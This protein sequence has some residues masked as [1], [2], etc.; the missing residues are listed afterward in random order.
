MREIWIDGENMVNDIFKLWT[1]EYRQIV[2][3]GRFGTKVYDVDSIKRN[4]R[5]IALLLM[6]K[7]NGDVMGIPRNSKNSQL[8]LEQLVTG[9][10][11]LFNGVY[12]GA[13]MRGLL[14]KEYVPPSLV[15]HEYDELVYVVGKRE[16]QW[17]VQHIR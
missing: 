1:P 10:S 12:S 16:K 2:L 17:L 6:S 5:A 11:V 8:L 7:Q 4:D 15:L 14:Q 13:H 9:R 3:D